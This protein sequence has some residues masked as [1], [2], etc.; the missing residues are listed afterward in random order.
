[1]ENKPLAVGEFGIVDATQI[2]PVQDH[3]KTKLSF[4]LVDD[5]VVMRLSITFEKSDSIIIGKGQLD[6]PTPL[7]VFKFG[8]SNRFSGGDL[9]NFFMFNAS[10]LEGIKISSTSKLILETDGIKREHGAS[11]HVLKT[12]QEENLRLKQMLANLI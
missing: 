4:E 6:Y 5:H 8:D 1:M 11:F 7:G 3:E 9:P 12:L 10:G 2:K